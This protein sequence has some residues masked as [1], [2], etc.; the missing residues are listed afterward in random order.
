MEYLDRNELILK[1]I[2]AQFEQRV[3]AR[4]DEIG[5]SRYTTFTSLG[6][7]NSSVLGEKVFLGLK[8]SF[9]G[10][11]RSDLE[12][13][14]IAVISKYCPELVPQLPLFYGFVVGS[15]DR[16]IGIITEDFSK[17][18]EFPVADIG[19]DVSPTNWPALLPLELH[20]LAPEPS[21]SSL[22]LAKMCFLVDGLMRLGDFDKFLFG[23]KM[24][25]VFKR[26]PIDRSFED[27]VKYT[28]KNRI[29]INYDL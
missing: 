9:L 14:R 1:E 29:Y 27:F 11:A 24:E 20:R 7:F 23:W 4:G 22:E 26:F 6:S 15:A 5:R 8:E 17:A 12:L 18:G 13:A 10:E 2:T 3:F 28:Q 19:T 25:D 21:L 16:E